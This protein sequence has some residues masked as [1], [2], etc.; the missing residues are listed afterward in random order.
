MSQKANN[1]QEIT[2]DKFEELL[3]EQSEYE[4]QRWTDLEINK[5]YTIT[6]CRT[7]DTTIGESVVL[8]LKDNGDVWCPAHLAKKIDGKEPPFYI[9]P[10]VLKPCKKNKKNKNHAYDLV[11]PKNTANYMH[12]DYVKN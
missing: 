10:L 6:S 9:R 12:K 3:K 4:T 2:I 5:I 8:T 1:I 11:L 7:V